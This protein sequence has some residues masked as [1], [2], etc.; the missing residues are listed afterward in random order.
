MIVEKDTEIEQFGALKG[1]TIQM[2]FAAE[3]VGQLMDNMAKSLYSR[4]KEAV[5]REYSTNALD[6]QIEVG[7]K[8][9][10]EITLPDPLGKQGPVLTIR[11]FGVGLDRKALHTIYSQYGA[12]TKRESNDFNGTLGLGS[13]SAFAYTNRFTVVSIKNGVREEIV[14]TRNE[15]GTAE[16]VVMDPLLT[17]ESSGTTIKIPAKRGDDF[18]AEAAKLYQWFPEG[19]VK[20]N[21]VVQDPWDRAAEGNLEIA[22]NMY[23]VKN[24]VRG[25]ST[26]E[27]DDLIVMGNVAYPTRLEGTGLERR[28]YHMVV[29]VPNGSVNFMSSREML[30]EQSSTTRNTLSKVVADFKNALQTTI[31]KHIDAAPSRP[32]AVRVVSDWKSLVPANVV[33]AGGWEY[34]GHPIPQELSLGK[35]EPHIRLLPL[36]KS[37]Y[38]NSHDKKRAIGHYYFPG[39]LWVEGFTPENVTATH[40]QKARKYI[41]DNGISAPR[42][43]VLVH[44]IPV[45]I[46]PWLAKVISYDDLKATKLPREVAQ[47]AASGRIPGSYDLWT[48]EP[49]K[50]TQHYGAAHNRKQGRFSGVPAEEFRHWKVPLFYHVGS[51]AQAR[52]IHEAL[53]ETAGSNGYT[54]VVFGSQR[55]AKFCRNFP[56]ARRAFDAIK[57]GYAAW[58]SNVGNDVALGL[59]IQQNWSS[60]DLKNLSGYASQIADPELKKYVEL[61]AKDL[62]K[63]RKSVTLFQI[64]LGRNPS[65]VP[66]IDFDARYPLMQE[67]SF[68]EHTVF[69]VNAV[70][71]ARANGATL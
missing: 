15:D 6:A 19:S 43:I 68:P 38:H 45:D 57:N 32:E 22:P 48:T 50:L 47:R 16:M 26:V 35:D 65:K 49:S 42:G 69:Y 41:E 63:E 44:Q 21:G 51:Y 66:L 3:A 9:P 39:T 64:V 58:A 11:D 24:R 40:G 8:R 46:R 1:E 36:Q 25:Y 55:E 67:A 70:Y 23:V 60:R 18:R 56:Q 12:S 33:P 71:N 4:P 17:D 30:N 14:V 7:V 28:K 52:Y 59:Q 5:L 34:K 53:A 27:E 29:F 13:K 61:A 37:G 31:Q 62:T 10:I 54:L 20:V 2:G